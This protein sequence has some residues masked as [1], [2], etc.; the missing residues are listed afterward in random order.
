LIIGFFFLDFQSV[1]FFIKCSFNNIR[2][3]SNWIVAQEK[4]GIKG[5][6]KFR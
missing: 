1:S 5:K 2:F 4:E 3:L 6:D